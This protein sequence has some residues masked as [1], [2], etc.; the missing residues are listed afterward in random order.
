ML[1]GQ[2]MATLALPLRFLKQQPQGMALVRAE[3][4][5]NSDKAIC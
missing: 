4:A 5:S 3:A 2:A 1:A